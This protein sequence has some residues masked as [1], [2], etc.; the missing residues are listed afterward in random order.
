MLSLVHALLLMVGSYRLR[1]ADPGL[2]TVY[3]AV[4]PNAT[5]RLR[6]MG[7][8]QWLPPAPTET[9]VRVVHGLD[10]VFRVGGI[11]IYCY[12]PA[13]ADAR[14]ADARNAHASNAHAR[15]ASLERVEACGDL[16]R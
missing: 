8:N 16:V 10:I 2:V 15:N 13:S 11:C 7:V 5:A 3:E 6:E 9:W 4:R 12:Q 1:E 14:N